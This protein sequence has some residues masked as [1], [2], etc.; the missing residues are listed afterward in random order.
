MK[1][2]YAK[3]PMHTE[4]NLVSEKNG[5]RTEVAPIVPTAALEAST[6]QAGSLYRTS[7]RPETTN[8]TNFNYDE[9]QRNW[10]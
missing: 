9:Q 2:E 7:F 10:Q 1:V 6:K 5:S 3:V 4:R 8:F